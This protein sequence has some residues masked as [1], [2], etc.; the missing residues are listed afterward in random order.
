MVGEE[1]WVLFLGDYFL[2][3]S[4]N[5]SRYLQQCIIS[6]RVATTAK[7]HPLPQSPTIHR[8]IHPRFPI[9]TPRH[10]FP[11]PSPLLHPP[12]HLRPR[13]PVHHQP[14]ANPQLLHIAVPSLVVKKQHLLIRNPRRLVQFRKM[15]P[16]VPG[17]D[18]Q[19][20]EDVVGAF[21]GCG[22]GGAASGG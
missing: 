7:P 6:R 17:E 3:C 22:G 12:I 8:T 14:K 9:P 10:H 16:F 20:V 21:R 19:V 13:H 2:V 18:L 11:P 1:N 15:L 5:S 4:S